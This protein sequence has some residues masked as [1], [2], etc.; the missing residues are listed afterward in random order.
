[1]M[2]SAVVL[3]AGL[4][5]RMENKNKL[6]LPYRDKTI[7]QITLANILAAGITDIVV[8]TGRDAALVT[9]LL[10][11]LPVRM[12]HNPGFALGL[13]GS[14]QKGVQ[15]AKGNGYMICLAD[16]VWLTAADYALLQQQF[17]LQRQLNA[18]CI[19]QP[20]Y[21]GSRGNP[22]VFA[23]TYREAILA[24]QAMEGC[25]EIVEANRASVYPVEMP[26]D[27]ILRDLDEPEDYRKLA[28]NEEI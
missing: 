12:V 13:T 14:I 4:S 8:V 7:L 23:D 15:E 11:P 21:R 9:S 17:A 5:S 6:L 22:V 28:D 26:N 2:L 18:A 1:M 25:R 20:V 16:M 3:A 27:H 24:H 10:Q 19:C